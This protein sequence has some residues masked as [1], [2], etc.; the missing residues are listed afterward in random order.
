VN[1][2]VAR[3]LDALLEASVVGG[4]SKVGVLARRHLFAWAPLSRLDGKTIAITGATSGLG[5]A[6]AEGAASLGADVV[7]VVRDAA[8]GLSVAAALRTRHGRPVDVVV[9][10][11]SDLAS[12]EAAADEL[13]ARG[14]LDAV[15][16][17][18]GALTPTPTLTA[19]GDELTFATH[20]LGPYLLTTRLLPTLR[21]AP[22]PRVVVVTSGG[23]YTQPL[24]VPRLDHVGDD[25]VGSAA[26]ARCKRAQVSLVDLHRA[27]LAAGGV[28]LAA[29]HPGWADTEG[30]RASLPGFRAVMRPLLR[31]PAEGADT[32]LWL[33]SAPRDAIG[34][35]SLFCDRAPRALHRITR[36]ERS[37]TTGA[38]AR[39]DQ[40]C[41]ARCELVDDCR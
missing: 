18:A 35:S 36:T 29:Y 9:G 3:G 32:A 10:D 2:P 22:D 24:D 21:Q 23:M 28:L 37:D 41:R 4:F 39:L 19:S 15:V 14:R 11:L 31:T 12:V 20:V 33:L 38:R 7:L 5:R 6:M 13:T 26:Y 16:H 1:R 17:N 25:Y 34:G 40:L 30:L 8:R 27:T